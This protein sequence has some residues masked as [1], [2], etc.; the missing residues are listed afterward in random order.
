MIIE[1]RTSS[2]FLKIVTTYFNSPP[3]WILTNSFVE[4]SGGRGSS[5]FTFENIILSYGF[6]VVLGPCVPM[7]GLGAK[8]GPKAKWNEIELSF[9]Y[10][11]IRPDKL[12]NLIVLCRTSRSDEKW[13]SYAHSKLGQKWCPGLFWAE[14]WPDFWDMD[15]KFVLTLIYINIKGK[16]YLEVN[17]TQIDHLSSEKHK[18]TSSQNAILA[19]C[20]S[21][22]S[23]LLLIF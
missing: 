18:T 11:S 21:L 19:K 6:R 1:P 10:Y 20:Q 15:F 3:C 16:P 17:W 8:N 2:K 12:I 13:P 23:L 9:L 4:Y 5:P 14:N 7:W 22:K